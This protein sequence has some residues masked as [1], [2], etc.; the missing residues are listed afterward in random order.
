MKLHWP[1]K[2]N[3][4]AFI[5][6]IDNPRQIFSV[7]RYPICT[8]VL[9]T[10]FSKSRLPKD[11]LESPIGISQKPN[12][13]TC[14]STTVN[15]YT[16]LKLILIIESPALSTA[17]LVPAHKRYCAIVSVFTLSQYTDH[18]TKVG[19]ALGTAQFDL[20]EIRCT[21]PTCQ[22]LLELVCLINVAC[23]SWRP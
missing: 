21:W 11:L 7:S 10:L 4:L 22:S 23:I 1:Y 3:S 2:H 9:E 12:N 19:K 13:E 5:W 20:E 6:P 15:R 17:P 16:C 8:R 18:L 14:V